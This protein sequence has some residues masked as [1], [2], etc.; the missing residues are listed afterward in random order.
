ML[1]QGYLF[2]V[3]YAVICLAL[4]LILYKL[5][6]PK[7]ITRKLVHILVGFEWVILYHFMGAGWH[8]LA[9]CLGF[10]AI[11]A[12]SHRKNL[13]P[14]IS[15]DGDNSP[16]TVYYGIAMSVMALICV[17][18][19]DMILPFGIGVFCTSLGDGLAGLFGQLMSFPKNVK[20]Y[21]NKTIYGTLVNFVVCVI[22]AGVFNATFQ[23]GMQIAHILL[24][25]LFATQLE[26]VTGKG[27][28]NISI[29][30]G[31]SFLTYFFVNYTGAYNY[32]L[33]IMLT[34]LIIVFAHK[35][36]ALTKDGIV[37][38]LLVD[39]VISITLGNL[40]FLLLLVFF[41]GGLITDKIKKSKKKAGQNTKKRSECRNS[42]QVL[43]NSAAA[44]VCAVLYFATSEKA[45]L[46]A[47]VASFAEALADTSASGIGALSSKAFDP[48][49]MKKCPVGLSGGMS[50]IGTF[51][52]LVGAALIS[53][54]SLPFGVI[55][56]TEALIACLGGFLGGV[57]DSFLGSVLQVKY[58]C[59]VCGAVV[60]KKEHCGKQTEKYSGLS[61]VTNNFV[62]FLGTIFAAIITCFIL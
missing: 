1:L 49:R 29:T 31:V 26:L 12:I 18:L 55:T 7:K 42:V 28:D 40:G 61:F 48:F 4:G 14:M 44:T 36:K 20:I 34:P 33:P 54:I 41:F 24:I 21:G 5:G 38:A 2:S 57:F 39:I 22:A 11:L 16:G 46:V 50:W 47:F 8:F 6:V 59:S 15:S 37:A 9:V 62:N 13:M 3:I 25:A 45:F 56:L 23:L 51:A 27:L 30:L 53:L 58:K 35:K 52:S 60:E 43:A 10:T 19:P 17:F 32:I